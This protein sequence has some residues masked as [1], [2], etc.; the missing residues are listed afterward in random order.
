MKI[1]D[2]NEIHEIS[3]ILW[4]SWIPQ[5]F[6]K[7]FVFLAQNQGLSGLKPQKPRKCWKFIISPKFTKISPFSAEF[8]DLLQKQ[9][10][11]SFL[12]ASGDSL[13]APCWKTWY[14]YRNIEV[15]S[16]PTPPGSLQNRPNWK[17]PTNLTTLQNSQS[18]MKLHNFSSNCEIS[19]FLT[20]HPAI[21]GSE[22][23]I[24]LG[25]NND[26]GAGPPKDT[27]LVKFTEKWR[28]LPFLLI[29]EGSSP[30]RAKKW[31]WVAFIV[32]GRI[33]PL[34]D[35]WI[36]FVFQWFGQLLGVRA[37]GGVRFPLFM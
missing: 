30:K 22:T 20:N 7:P 13:A 8:L 29:L 27:H 14:S 37:R 26:L 2:F 1:R 17:T 12:E 11:H 19:Q 4:F 5:P 16:L 34:R 35:L 21:A 23:L 15:L 6:T 31:F 10:K 18:F 25:E 24:L 3:C 33:A 9:R 28:N 36:C 32:S